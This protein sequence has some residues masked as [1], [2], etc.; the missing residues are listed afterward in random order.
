MS[1]IGQP[2]RTNPA[3]SARTMPRRHRLMLLLAFEILVLGFAQAAVQPVRR[4]GITIEMSVMP[5]HVV[6]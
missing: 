6:T 5:H 2:T 4:P 1:T 3:Q